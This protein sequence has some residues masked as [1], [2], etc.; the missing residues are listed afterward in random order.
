MTH[1]NSRIRTD[2]PL[3]EAVLGE[4]VLECMDRA[5]SALLPVFEHYSAH[6]QDP[7]ETSRSTTSAAAGA[8]WGETAAPRVGF[9]VSVA[10]VDDR[11]QQQPINIL[12][13]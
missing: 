11:S 9:G 6:D 12:Q 5:R 10:S 4:E 13:V 8:S 3:A 1:D 7:A 2:D